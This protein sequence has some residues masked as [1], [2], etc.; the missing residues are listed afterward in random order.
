MRST[1]AGIRR[2]RTVRPVAKSPA[3]VD[4]IEALVAGCGEDLHGGRDRALLR[5]GLAGA[6]G[7]SELAATDWA[8]LAW[9]KDG[10][11]VFLPSSKT[12]REG[13]GQEVAVLRGERL[14]PVLALVDAAVAGHWP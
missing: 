13:S 4:I 1:L 12:D 5:L 10:L 14:C 3:T 11:R 8:H 7:R 9:E 2:A 6:F